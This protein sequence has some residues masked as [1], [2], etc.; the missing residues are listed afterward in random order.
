MRSMLEHCVG[1]RTVDYAAG[2]T[3][4][5]EGET[6]GR[7]Y[8]LLDGRLDVVKGTTVV[9]SLSDPGATVGE[10]S[11]L[12]DQPHSATVIAAQASTIYA[13]DNAA[14]F[15]ESHPSLALLLARLLAIR[16]GAATTYL[17]D[18]KRQYAGFGNHLEMVGDVLR[19]LVNL[20]A[21][22]VSPGSDRRADPRL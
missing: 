13:F 12:L 11:V 10:M 7:L 5:Q 15:L 21:T 14:Q 20:P 6:T 16:L 17:A 18:I 2:D 9:A 22:E 19:S 3:V 8:V 4:I 1:G